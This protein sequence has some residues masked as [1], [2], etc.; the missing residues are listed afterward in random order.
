MH[1]FGKAEG[2]DGLQCYLGLE[3]AAAD[4]ERRLG[5]MIDAVDAAYGRSDGDPSVLKVFLAPEFFFR[6]KVRAG[7]GGILDTARTVPS[8]RGGAS[9]HSPP[10]PGAA[11]GNR[12]AVRRRD[13]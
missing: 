3:D 13:R 10:P 8:G 4:V 5:I 1:S 7:F 6:W 2:E 9:P 11:G 12:V